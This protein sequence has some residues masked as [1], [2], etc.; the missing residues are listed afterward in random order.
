MHTDKCSQALLQLRD[1]IKKELDDEDAAYKTYD[2]MGAKFVELGMPDKSKILT[3]I[4][5]SEL[6][7]FVILSTIVT[8][9]DDICGVS[10][11]PKEQPKVE[12]PEPQTAAQAA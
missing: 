4:S 11:P 5:R 10:E 9:I 12:V 3:L 7:H 6:E 2:A 1:D 8:E